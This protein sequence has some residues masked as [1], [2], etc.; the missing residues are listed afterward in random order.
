VKSA[1]HLSNEIERLAALRRYEILDTMPE[2]ALDD[3]TM[4][5]GHICDAPIALIS[6]V[7]EQRQW[8]KSKVGLSI[9]ETARDISFCG[10]V[11]AQPDLFVVPDADLDD[12]FADSPLVTGEPHVRFYA[13]MPLITP[14]GY[15]LGTL[16]VFDR[17][18]R[19]LSSTQ[20]E[21]LR[22]L[23]R[24]V[25]AQ[26][27]LRRQSRE[28]LESETRLF[29]VFRNCPVGVAI[30][31]WSDRTFVDVNAAFT[32][33]FG[34]ERDE[35][36][37]HTTE[38]MGI[39][40]AHATAELRARIG[41]DKTASNAELE[42]RTREGRIRHVLLGTNLTELYGEPHTITTFVDIT[43][44]RVAEIASNR[45]AAIVESSSDAIIGK[46][47]DGMITSWNRGATKI[48]GFEPSEIIGS[49]IMRLIPHDREDEERHILQQIRSGQ[50][51]ESFETVRRAKDGQL[52][53]VSVTASPIKDAAGRVIGAS[54]VARNITER[55]RAEAAL[56]ASEERMRFALENAEIGIWDI[57]YATGVVRWSTT[58]EA[59]YG[60]QPGAFVGTIEAVVE[61]VHPD[62][63]SA[64]SSTLRTAAMSGEDFTMLNRSIWPNGEVHWLSGAGRFQLGDGGRPTR[65]L[66][67]SMDITERR[68]LEEQY[69]QAQKMEAV[70]RLAGGVAHDFNNL[71]T[72]I[73][74]YCELLLRDIDEGDR[75]RNDV[76]E[77]QSAGARATR[78]TRQLL[79]FSRKQ[80]VEPAILDFN[81]L[82]TDL[83]A[84]LG[85]LIGEDVEIVLDLVPDVWCVMA[86]R[87]QIEQIVM[88]LFVNARDAMPDGGVITLQT[89]NVALDAQYSNAH[90]G[91]SAG[92]YVA[93]VV[94]DTGTGMTPAVQARIFEPFFT[95][96]EVGRGTGLGM[97]TVFGIVAQSGGSIDVRSEINRG[98]SFRIYFPRTKLTEFVSGA[99]TVAGPTRAVTQT[100][101]VVEDEEG[102]RELARRLLERLGY[103]IL[104]AANA[105][106]AL[107][108]VD[109]G[110]PIDVIL[111]DVIMPGTSG[112]ELVAQ[113]L[114]RRPLL[115]V[116]YMSG[117]TD[118]AIDHHGV[119]K[120]GIAFLNKPFT[121]ESLDEKLRDV[122]RM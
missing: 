3:L 40:E 23:S 51:I 113:L 9:T 107:K 4:L 69:Q 60:L 90:P 94:T 95:T 117:Y 56:K 19:R 76:A 64:V 22:A 41:V 6:L 45:L 112:P 84:M 49:S 17:V 1:P 104:V 14:D 11:I 65:G 61:R 54:K 96:K 33:L 43:E 37:G 82:A 34:F 108:L 53:D 16:C 8:F 75:R 89:E 68:T 114:E 48:F 24:Q 97:A 52:L 77:I 7:D 21:A 102:V 10:H 71:L 5:A 74:G 81:Q 93:L 20:E 28:L 83:E 101:L 78:L 92:D 18:P 111:T 119:L 25:M 38:E 35:L 32:T 55:K 47:L 98:T 118:E 29:H 110:L 120:P 73:L 44:R 67:I 31:R 72:V 50:S 87:G 85:R 70:G 2:Q 105:R 66:G 100:V 91:A 109:D 30:H 63:R 62:D 116:L 36:F 80:I 26:L 103:T 115:R 79:A 13:G 27:N 58:L 39:V 121:A 59:Q 42:V 15:G 122:L 88:N 46:D 12:R 106:E 86:D 57:D 99:P